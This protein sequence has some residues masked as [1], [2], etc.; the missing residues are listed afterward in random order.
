MTKCTAVANAPTAAANVTITTPG[1]EPISQ[2]GP[3]NNFYN[4]KPNNNSINMMPEA[5]SQNL[6]PSTPD[7]LA[8][9]VI[10]Q[11]LPAAAAAVV[12]NSQEPLPASLTI[13]PPITSSSSFSSSIIQSQ[14]PLPTVSKPGPPTFPK[15]TPPSNAV[16]TPW[17]SG[18]Q[19]I[20]VS[21]PPRPTGPP[22][23]CGS[24]SGPGKS[25]VAGLRQ[26]MRG[27]GQLKTST[28]GTRIPICGVCQVPIRL[29][30]GP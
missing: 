12:A 27:R 26:P 8:A 25:I 24:L 23:P 19:N 4:N 30:T 9:E 1:P 13:A 10:N 28:P 7:E 6:K 21:N 15:P 11:A 22:A 20:N 3:T 16:P 29:V 5:Q 14:Q 2:G 18:P 17:S